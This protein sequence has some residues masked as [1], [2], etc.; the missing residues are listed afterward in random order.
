MLFGELSDVK[1]MED[2][3]I[4]QAGEIGRSKKK[5]RGQK[6]ARSTSVSFSTLR[7]TM[8]T[9]GSILSLAAAGGLIYLAWKAIEIY[10]GG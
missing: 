1:K 4:R 6:R 2:P 3:E 10:I 8:I 7:I 9:V 5:I